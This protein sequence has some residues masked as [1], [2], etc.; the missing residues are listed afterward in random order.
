MSASALPSSTLPAS[1]TL[2]TTT[3]GASHRS[4]CRHFILISATCSWRPILENIESRFDSYLTQENQLNRQKIADNRIH[5]CIYFLQPTGHALKQIDVE[6]MRRLHTRVNLIPVIAKADTLTDEEIIKFKQRVLNDI[7]HHQIQIFQ[8]PIYDNDDEETIAENEE[9]AAK[10][11][12]AVVGSDREVQTADGRSVR[13][14][15]YP[16]GVIEVDNEEHCDFVKLRQML[17]RTNMEELREHTNDVLYE[18]WRSEKLTSMGVVQDPSVFKEVKYVAASA[19]RC[20]RF[21]NLF[22]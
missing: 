2:S 4:L 6:F 21:T 10:I 7:A 16:W 8:A 11:P 5:A 13:G 14:R 15:A 3:T 17:I 1:V 19:R 22:P 20:Q 9:I 12:F 18:N